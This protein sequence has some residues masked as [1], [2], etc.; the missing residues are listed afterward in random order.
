MGGD[1]GGAAEC[2]DWGAS[3]RR[4]GDGA[5]RGEGSRSV[6][7]GREAGVCGGGGAGGFHLCSAVRA[8]PGDQRGSGGAGGVRGG[9]EW[10]GAG[11]G[12]SGYRES[13]DGV[14][15]DVEALGWGK[16]LATDNTD[17]HG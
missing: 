11:G 10:A 12:E 3:S 6:P 2:E 16:K 9:A 4:V 14:G 13:G 1:G 5:V 8:A 15:C 7:V 17:E